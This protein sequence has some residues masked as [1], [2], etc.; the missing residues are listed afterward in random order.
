MSY[1]S[2]Y[3][4]DDF[5]IIT[6]YWISDGQVSPLDGDGG[7]QF[8]KYGNKTVDSFLQELREAISTSLA[9]GVAE[10]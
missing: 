3:N 6:G 10:K 9:K 4:G 7:L 8:S 2:R 5:D 1:F